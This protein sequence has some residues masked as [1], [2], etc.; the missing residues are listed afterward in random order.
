[1]AL[2]RGVQKESSIDREYFEEGGGQVRWL[3]TVIET[4][5][6]DRTSID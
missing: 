4:S 2:S 6:D 3:K 5:G 1:M